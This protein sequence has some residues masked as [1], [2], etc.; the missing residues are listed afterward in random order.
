VASIPDPASVLSCLFGQPPLTLPILHTEGEKKRGKT[1]ARLFEPH[2]R[3]CIMHRP[4]HVAYDPSRTI[5]NFT[6]IQD[7]FFFGVGV[8]HHL[9]VKSGR[10]LYETPG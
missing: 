2:S 6:S 7:P 1:T 3:S 10:P 8:E 9:A 4:S 5:G